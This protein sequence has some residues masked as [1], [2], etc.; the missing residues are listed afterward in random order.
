MKKLWQNLEYKLPQTQVLTKPLIS[1]YVNKFFTFIFKEID[2]NKQYLV[3]IFRILLESGSIKTITKLQKLNQDSKDQL[4]DFINDK[5]NLVQNS[6]FSE[7]ISS[8]ILSYG[9][10]KGSLEQS[11][12]DLKSAPNINYHIYYNNH[13][14]ISINPSD[15]GKILYQSE[16]NKTY[17]IAPKKNINLLIEV[18]EGNHYI[19]FFKNSQLMY[20]WIDK[21]NL[22][23]NSITREI[24][25]TTI[26]WKDGEIIWIKVLKS[27]K[28]ISKKRASSHLNQNFI[29]M[30]LETLSNS[31]NINKEILEL[32]LICFYDGKNKNSYLINNLEFAKLPKEIIY[33]S[34]KELCRRKYSNFNIYLHNFAKF[35]AI[36]LI[37]HL[38]QIGEC[39]PIIHKGKIISFEFKYNN[40]T[41][42][43]RDSYLILLASLDKLSKGFNVENPKT[44]FPILFNDINYSGE[45]PNI[46]Y[47]KDISL[48]EYNNYKTLFENK[49]WSFKEESIN[50]CFLDCISL[51]Q[52]LTKFNKLIFENFHLDFNDYPTLSALAF[53]I[54][55][56]KYLKEKPINKQESLGTGTG[57][58]KHFSDKLKTR[59][60]FSPIK[61]PQQSRVK[62]NKP[63]IKFE[64]NIAMLSGD[65][66]RDIRQSYTGGS[67]DMFIPKPPIGSKIYSY[68]VNSLYPFVM[69]EYKYPIGNP[70]Y[71][72]G[73]LF[74]FNPELFGFF[75]C[76][77]T[78]PEYLDHPI[79][80][81]HY[82][83]NAGVRTISPLGSWSGWFFSEELKNS[84]K[85]GYQFEV[86]RGYYFNSGYLFKDY[87]NDLYNLRLR[88]PKSDPM[89]YIAKILLNSL[90]GR[91]G[92]DDNFSETEILTVKEYEGIEDYGL[93]IIDVI[94][95]KDKFMVTSKDPDTYLKTRLDYSRVASGPVVI[96]VVASQLAVVLVVPV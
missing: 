87:V 16:D 7:P 82:K 61:D 70:T 45:V 55:R 51:Y 96:V 75:Y 42:T 23:D 92:M 46:K 94:P 41:V 53:S 77:V 50:Y 36:F 90:Y 74:K 37:K 49:L 5:V 76:K 81:T 40:I 1:E 89:N 88:Y 6:Y 12:L 58:D 95:L 9:I 73:N 28:T 10:R 26:Y 79:L 38:A 86:L 3:L 78:T 30:D 44:L 48:E 68:D 18:K 65:I 84:L 19:K 31:I 32:Y 69:K 24:G 17:L 85:F 59:N 63:T 4:I 56:S 35:D 14:P 91:F 66:A 25:K 2:P 62:N 52:I 67:T 21:I 60:V 57:K 13:L 71:F 15:Y 39:L 11:T 34:M 72:E 43:F 93:D 80:Q 54:F 33:R 8:I 47:F 83:T 29:T 27:F 22:K 64:T 20:E